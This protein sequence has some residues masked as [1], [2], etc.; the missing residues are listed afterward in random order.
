MCLSATFGCGLFC[1]FASERMCCWLLMRLCCV[2]C[3]I[4]EIHGRDFQ[5]AMKFSIV[6]ER[7]VGKKSFMA[8]AK[9]GANQHLGQGANIASLVRS[10]NAAL[11]SHFFSGFPAPHFP[12]PTNF[13]CVRSTMLVAS[14]S[15]CHWFVG[16]S[17]LL[18]VLNILFGV[19]ESPCVSVVCARGEGGDGRGVACACVCVCVCMCKCASVQV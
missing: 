7:G 8:R 6:G 14:R 2:M 3:R 1:L 19:L 13:R 18:I 12:S 16:N 17:H 4:Q 11:T 5:V 9:Y 10:Q 15:T